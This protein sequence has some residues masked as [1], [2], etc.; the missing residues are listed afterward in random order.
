MQALPTENLNS[1][2]IERDEC[3]EDPF[4]LLIVQLMHYWNCDQGL[5]KV[6]GDGQRDLILRVIL[7]HLLTMYWRR[8]VS[9]C[10]DVV[11][12]HMFH[13]R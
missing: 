2:W 1:R 9:A 8:V 4:N 12:I 10:V 3:S 6:I 5:A 7:K 11:A 13:K